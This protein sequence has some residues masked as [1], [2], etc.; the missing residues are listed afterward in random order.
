MATA[1]TDPKILAE[2]NAPNQIVTDPKILAELNAPDTSA[3]APAPQSSAFD[4]YLQQKGV[5][6]D[7][8]RKVGSTSA[9]QPFKDLP[10]SIPIVKP[11]GDP[12]TDLLGTAKNIAEFPARL[13]ATLGSASGPVSDAVAEHLGALGLPAPISAA[14]AIASGMAVDPRNY[15]I[16]GAEN[17]KPEDIPKLGNFGGKG[18]IARVTQAEKYGIDLTPAQATQNKMLGFLEAVGN[19]YPYSA[20]EFTNFYK[21]ELEQADNIRAT[22][23]DTIGNTKASQTV[24]DMMKS[25]IDNYL[26]N[27]TPE[28]ASVLQDQFGDLDAYMKKPFAGQFT[29][30]MLAQQRKIALDAAGA[31]FNA[32]DDIVPPSTPIKAPTFIAKAKELLDKELQGDPNDRNP[33]WIKRLSSYAGVQNVPGLDLSEAV[34]GSDA[35]NLQKA[36]QDAMGTSSGI[37]PFAETQMTMRKLRD[38]R[39]SSDPGYLLGIKGQGNTYAGYAAQLRKALHSD[40]ENALQTISSQAK[41][42]LDKQPPSDPVAVSDLQKMITASDQFSSAKAN[43]A[44]TKT[45]MNDPFIIKLLKQNPEDFLNHAVKAQDITNVGKLKEILGPENFAPVQENLLANMLVDKEGNLSPTSFVNKVDKIGMP[46]LTKVFDPNTLTEIV[47]S[48]K[49]F[50]SM[51]GMEKQVGNPSGTAGVMMARGAL[52]GTSMNAMS[53]LLSG[54]MGLAAQILGTGVVLPKV[55]S[56]MYLSSAMRDLLIHGVSSPNSAA[57]AL[58][59]LAKAAAMGGTRIPTTSNTSFAP[60]N[61]PMQGPQQ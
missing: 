11:T 46:T 8:L 60:S 26:Q 38:L 34:T 9:M 28:Q 53:E 33:A 17:L 39:I 59:V 40:Q 32:L 61:P 18:T 41:Q 14:L 35:S 47:G 43:Y 37:K 54:R 16:G 27:A 36:I 12:M 49:V 29:Q 42:L 10:D 48:Q 44:Q 24:S 57:I 2:L 6:W 25:H 31:Q 7:A 58:S 22:L 52:F 5:F 55:L 3:S 50:K 19:R 21:N 51:Y 20:D 4:D 1:V 15:V 23:I 56:K 13:S 45:L 30:S